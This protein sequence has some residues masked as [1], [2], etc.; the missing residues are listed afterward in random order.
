VVRTYS[1]SDYLSDGQAPGAEYRLSIKKE[2]APKGSDVPPGLAS[3]Y[4]HEHVH[5]GSKMMCRPPSGSF[6][7]SSKSNRPLALVSNGVGITPMITMAK[8]ARWMGIR[9]QIWFVHGARNG[10]H[11][12]F[13]QE[14]ATIDHADPDFHV[15]VTYSRPRLEDEGHYQSQGHVDP[16]LLNRLLPV[17]CDLYLCGSPPFMDAMLA[18]LQEQGIPDE[19]IFFEVFSRSPQPAATAGGEGDLPGVAHA[20]ISFLRSGLEAKWPGEAENLLGFAEEQG[21]KPPFSCR[22]GVCGTCRCRVVEGEV[23]TIA[24]PTAPVGDGEALIC[25]SRPA[26]ERVVLDL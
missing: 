13:R 11:Q 5:V 1:L 14:I 23:V 24:P 9:Q 12:A 16:Q 25:I 3:T 15:H 8:A 22:A 17:D 20:S 19:R 7:L 4:L 2:P 26:S 21:L 6:V 10:S 18:G